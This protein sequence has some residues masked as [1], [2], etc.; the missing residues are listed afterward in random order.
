MYKEYLTPVKN[1]IKQFQEVGSEIYEASFTPEVKSTLAEFEKVHNRI[2]LMLE[3]FGLG[4]YIPPAALIE[5]LD[6]AKKVLS[7]DLK[8]THPRLLTVGRPV[9]PIVNPRNFIA[10]NKS[11]EDTLLNKLAEKLHSHFDT[12]IIN[13]TT[14]EGADAKV[15]L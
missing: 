1:S 11:F 14:A 9:Y 15:N 2:S 12:I 3:Q 8:P 4:A 7:K 13:I 6:Y 5:T 10:Q